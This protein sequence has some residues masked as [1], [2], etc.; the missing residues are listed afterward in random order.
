MIDMIIGIAIG[1]AFAPFWM[2]VWGKI[3]SALASA[4]A[5]PKE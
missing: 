1:S 5:A 2:M 4:P 3:K